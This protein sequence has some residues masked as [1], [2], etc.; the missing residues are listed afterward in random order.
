MPRVK[1]SG[2]GSVFATT[3]GYGI[4]WP[5]DGKR[6]QKTGFRTRTEARRW[7]ADNVAPRLGRSAPSSEISYDRFG[8]IFL[9][10]HGAT[11]ADSTRVTLADRL[12]HSR[13]RFG[14]WTLRE[15]EDAS[16]DV[17]AWRAEYDD[18]Q[19]YRVTSAMR[20]VLAAAAVRWKYIDRNAAVD[21][22]KNPQPRA[23][24]IFP[25]T[26]DEV[27]MIA[28]E[29]DRLDAARVTVAAE[30]GLRPE[31]WIALER[32]DLD[33]AGRALA[34]QRKYAKGVMRPY[35]K[36]HRARRRVPLT[37]TAFEAIA[38]LPPRVDTALL[39]PAPEGGY[40]R[41]D[42]WR[43][44]VWYPA[45]DAAGISKRGP[46]HLRHTFATEALAAG[47]STFELSRVMGTSLAMI[48][49]HYGHLARDSE[50]SI[51]ARLDARNAQ[52]DAKVA[53]D[54]E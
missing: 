13:G 19:R 41:L 45:L 31:E 52:S 46:Y 28:A 54:G 36:S 1:G 32:R 24:E 4:R 48:D 16:A 44:R 2:R 23:E 39:F 47:V 51:R 15:L 49:I 6:P 17:A 22:G 50:E 7:F 33:R 5:E 10:R 35:G 9:A 26:P 38:A 25:F 27:D 29:L 12:V 40:L 53:S 34:V 18:G 14:A 20:Q 3:D 8:E 21:A 42:N 37:A 30:T 43:N 11:I